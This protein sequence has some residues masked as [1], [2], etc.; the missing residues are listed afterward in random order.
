MSIFCA[1]RGLTPARV[2][3]MFLSMTYHWKHDRPISRHEFEKLFPDD[4]ACARHLARLRWGG[5]FRCPTCGSAK[6]WELKGERL[7]RECAGCGRQTSVTAG[8]VM[9]RSHLPLRTWFLAT[10]SNGISALQLQA[11]LGIGSYKSAWLLLHKLRRAMV[12]PNRSLLRGTAEVDE[13]SVPFRDGDGAEGVASR[14]RGAAGRILMAGAVE[15]SEGGQPRR[16][17]L[18]TI[19]DY[20]SGALR[21]FIAGAV[22]PDAWVVTDGWSGYAGL[23]DNPREERVVGDRKAHEV[24]VWVH[25]VFSHLKRWALGVY[26]GLRRKHVQRYL[27]EFVFR[28]NRRRHRRTS[29]DSLLGIGLGLPPATYRDFAEGRA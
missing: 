1:R 5:G 21:G 16:I 25:R 12:D 9:H 24:L 19:K 20:G 11:Q 6:G 8:T 3:V 17:R 7:L 29:F 10:H 2:L 14:G 4:D 23:P 28:W 27:D 15:L 18:E 13:A 22:T 26:H